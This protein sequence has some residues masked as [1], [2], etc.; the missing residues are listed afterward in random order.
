MNKFTFEYPNVEA[1]DFAN[2]HTSWKQIFEQ[3]LSAY[4]QACFGKKI[5]S[6]VQKSPVLGSI[7]CQF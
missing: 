1:P 3:V 5:Y 6:R 4:A 2:Q 7:L